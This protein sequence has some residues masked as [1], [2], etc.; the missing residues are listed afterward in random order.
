[1]KHKAAYGLHTSRLNIV[2]DLLLTQMNY[3]EIGNWK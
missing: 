3:L 2:S 1:M